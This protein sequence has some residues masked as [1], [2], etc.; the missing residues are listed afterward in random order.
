ME[1]H[2]PTAYTLD[3]HSFFRLPP[4]FTD[5]PSLHL[6]KQITNDVSLLRYISNRKDFVLTSVFL[7]TANI[8]TPKIA[9]NKALV[10]V[11]S[12]K[13]VSFLNAKPV[14]RKVLIFSVLYGIMEHLLILLFS[15]QIQQK[16]RVK[17]NTVNKAIEGAIFIL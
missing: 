10:P 15:K 14:P 16:S 11:F 2:S 7:R 3:L 13:P 9:L 1:K 5:S 6:Q 12:T 4:P 8:I 17:C